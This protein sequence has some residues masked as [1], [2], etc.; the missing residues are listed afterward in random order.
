MSGIQ[1]RKNEANPSVAHWD[2]CCWRFWV[3]QNHGRPSIMR[4]DR[5]PWGRPS[6]MDG[7]P[8]TMGMVGLLPWFWVAQN[9]QQSISQCATDGFASFLKHWI[10]LDWLH[11]IGHFMLYHVDMLMCVFEAFNCIGQMEVLIFLSQDAISR[12]IFRIGQFLSVLIH[13]PKP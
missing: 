3:I 12:R 5:P 4:C 2:I 8:P 6:T 7:G 9:L 1:R 10:P 11:N 13:W